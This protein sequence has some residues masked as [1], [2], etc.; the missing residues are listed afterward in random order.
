MRQ[1]FMF[2]ISTRMC[3]WPRQVPQESRRKKKKKEK[4]GKKVSQELSDTNT[5][6]TWASLMITPGVS[7]CTFGTGRRVP[8]QAPPPPSPSLSRGGTQTAARRLAKQRFL[9]AEANICQRPLLS[10]DPRP[11][12][13][14]QPIVVYS[15]RSMRRR[16]WEEVGGGWRGRRRGMKR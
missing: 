6:D 3:T 9:S 14:L 7:T 5:G 11:A 15:L 4:K 12:R 2:N 1:N 16:S 13:T 8:G 10:P